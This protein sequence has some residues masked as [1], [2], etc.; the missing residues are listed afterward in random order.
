MN[1]TKSEVAAKKISKLFD[2]KIGFSGERNEK[3]LAVKEDD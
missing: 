3:K 1:E 2:E